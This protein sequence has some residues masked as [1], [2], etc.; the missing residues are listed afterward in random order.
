MQ[1]MTTAQLEMLD[2]FEDI[3]KIIPRKAY[4]PAL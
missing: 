1:T 3:L 2:R 4:E